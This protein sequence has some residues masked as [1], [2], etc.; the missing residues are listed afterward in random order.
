MLRLLILLRLAMPLVG[1]SHVAPGM[2]VKRLFDDHIFKLWLPEAADVAFAEWF[3]ASLV[4]QHIGAIVQQ[5]LTLPAVYN[6]TPDEW[7]VVDAGMNRGYQSLIPAKLGYNV[8][9]IEAMPACIAQASTTLRLNNL[10]AT[11]QV[12]LAGLAQRSG[13]FLPVRANAQCN[14]GNSIVAEADRPDQL[15][16]PGEAAR[17]ASGTLRV[18]LRSLPSMLAP[19]K[20]GIAVMKM[21]IEGSE[22]AA[23]HEFGLE[24]FVKYQ[25]KNLIVEIC[26]HL[27]RG[28]FE[29]GVAFLGSLGATSEGVYCLDP[30]L[31]VPGCAFPVIRDPVLGVLHRVEDMKAAVARANGRS[32]C[33]NLWFRSIG[34]KSV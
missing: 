32:C 17:S 30:E 3:R 28:S 22:M 25:I 2:K 21:D 14:A 20:K 23:L 18:P 29:E 33:G 16:R 26:S 27:W 7:M 24:G 4:E 15:S 8:L 5:L 1:P 12:V 6:F 34:N 10:S 31:G 9:A 11:V 19:L 13:G